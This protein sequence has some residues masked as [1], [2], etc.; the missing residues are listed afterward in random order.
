ML[1]WRNLEAAAVLRTVGEIRG[2]ASPSGSTNFG[3]IQSSSVAWCNPTGSCR[4][5]G[6]CNSNEMPQ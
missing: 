5:G 2:G 1:P 4:F 3:N 6:W